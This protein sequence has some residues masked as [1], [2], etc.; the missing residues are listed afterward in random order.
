MPNAFV[1]PGGVVAKDDFNPS[2][3][4]ILPE[5]MKSP[6]N[7]PRPLLMQSAEEGEG[8]PR[9]VAFRSTEVVD[10]ISEGLEDQMLKNFVRI[11]AIRETFEESGVLLLQPDSQDNVPSMEASK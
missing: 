4:K 2:W 7:A 8:L 1:F 5:P 6:P 9:H 11:A 3:L 10:M